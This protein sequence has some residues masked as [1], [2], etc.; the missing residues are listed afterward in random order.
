[1][2]R[3]RAIFLLLVPSADF[4]SLYWNEKVGRFYHDANFLKLINSSENLNYAADLIFDFCSEL[5]FKHTGKSHVSVF[6]GDGVTFYVPVMEKFH[7]PL[8]F[9][10]ACIIE[11]LPLLPEERA[12]KL[13][14]FFSLLDISTYC[15]IEYASGYNP[16]ASLLTSESVDEKWKRLADFKMTMIVEKELSGKAKPRE[17]WEKAFQQYVSIF[18]NMLYGELKYPK[19]LYVRQLKFIL[20]RS[21]HNPEIHDWQFIRIFNLIPEKSYKDLRYAVARY[22]LLEKKDSSRCFSIYS[23][24]TKLF[25]DLV[26]KEFGCDKALMEKISL[27]EKEREEKD[28]ARKI[29]MDKE[30]AREDDVLSDM[31]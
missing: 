28:L 31:K 16:F 11:L 12:K 23:E 5:R 25:V 29:F 9:Y 7:A 6:G 22:A 20:E 13:F 15:N 14:S 27:L 19:H 24:E 10:N 30:K 18:Q 17:K 26:K 8:S 2:T 1:M 3:K 4:N 21:A